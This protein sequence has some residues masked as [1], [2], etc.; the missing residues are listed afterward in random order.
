MQVFVVNVFYNEADQPQVNRVFQLNEDGTQKEITK[1]EL[2]FEK[3]GTVVLACE[4]A[5]QIMGTLQQR[6][7]DKITSF[8]L[9]SETDLTPQPEESGTMQVLA[10]GETPP[11]TEPVGQIIFQMGI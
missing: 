7:S 10:E 5:T 1:E 2:L 8:E 11:E 9:V 6:I 3:S 4:D